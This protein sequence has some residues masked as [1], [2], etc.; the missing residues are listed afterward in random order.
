MSSFIQTALN[1]VFN[2]SPN[3]YSCPVKGC[4]IKNNIHFHIIITYLQFLDA[5]KSPIHSSTKFKSYL[6]IRHNVIYNIYARH[7]KAFYLRAYITYASFRISCSYLSRIF[8]L[9][10]KS[11]IFR[12]VG[13]KKSEP[14]QKNGLKLL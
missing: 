11:E 9:V 14:M 3:P 8:A 10:L 1:F 13:G 2:V 5:T 7:F 4:S 12:P 6:S